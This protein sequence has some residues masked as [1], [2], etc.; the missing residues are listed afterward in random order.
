MSNFLDFSLE[1]IKKNNSKIENDLKLVDRINTIL[2]QSSNNT[3]KLDV[4]LK[5]IEDDSIKTRITKLEKLVEKLVKKMDT[6][7][8]NQAKIINKVNGLESKLQEFE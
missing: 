3:S 2:S 4:V 7:L 8:D 6:C 5:A 1:N